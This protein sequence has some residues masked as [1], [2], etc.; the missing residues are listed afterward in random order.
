MIIF[1][2]SYWFM[3]SNKVKQFQQMQETRKNCFEPK[4]HNTTLRQ[5]KTS[6]EESKNITAKYYVAKGNIW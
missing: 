6:K 3:I 1:I 5:M 2:F 4:K